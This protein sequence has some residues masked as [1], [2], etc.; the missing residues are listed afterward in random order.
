MDLGVRVVEIFFF[1]CLSRWY[2]RVDEVSDPVV[3]GVLI[4]IMRIHRQYNDI[5]R[6]ALII[7]AAM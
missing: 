2:G 7:K 5:C 4:M 3:A 6:E 1:C